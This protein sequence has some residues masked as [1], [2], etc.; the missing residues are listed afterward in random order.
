[1]CTHVIVGT[2]IRWLDGIMVPSTSNPSP[3]A[4]PPPAILLRESYREA[5]EA[6][7]G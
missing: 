2:Y 4:T 1:M 3:I 7:P 5:G 6:H